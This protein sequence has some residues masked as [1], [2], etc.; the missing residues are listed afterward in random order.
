[1]IIFLFYTPKLSS[2]LGL[3]DVPYDF[4]SGVI[5]GLQKKSTLTFLLCQMVQFMKVKRNFA[6]IF[7]HGNPL[8]DWTNCTVEPTFFV[9]HSANAMAYR[10]LR[11]RYLSNE[12]LV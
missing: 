1:M 2:R 11:P 5:A 4:I 8:S 6:H 3:N 7:A 9:G 10:R 12:G